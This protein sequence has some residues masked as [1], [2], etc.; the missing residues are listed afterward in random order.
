MA[1]APNPPADMT[2][3]IIILHLEDSPRDTELIRER[4][5]G[6]GFNAQVDWAASEPEFE[7]FLLRNDYDIILADYHVT[8]FEGP[9]SLGR[10]HALR[11]GTPYICVS[12]AIGEDCAVELLRLGAT[13]Y[14]SKDRLAR[15]PFVIRRALAETRDH[16]EHKSALEL[17]LREKESLLKEIHHRV[18]NNLQIVSSLLRLQSGRID[19]PAAKAALV[20]MQNRVRSM[21]L[22]H[23][24]LYGSKNLAQVDM[25]AY[26]RSLCPKLVRA[27]MTN[28]KVIELQL[29]LSP[30][31][32]EIDQAIPCG[33]LVNE[34]LTNALKHAFPD[35]RT[36][37]VRVELQPVDG[38]RQIRLLVADN[39][40]GLPAN[41]DVKRLSSLGL[42][43]VSD[44][45]GQL[46]GRLE[47]GP[48]PGA[49]FEVVFE[50]GQ[51]NCLPHRL[52]GSRDYPMP[53]TK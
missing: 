12:G 26:I 3:E 48:G 41:L 8:G 10:A 52:D 24:H 11:P 27:L 17:S 37:E 6:E 18:K 32:L 30:V 31:L 2:P 40:I 9:A 5:T 33:L 35:G 4:L 22:V 44:L 53:N 36:G 21:A 15:L 7:S 28:P 20:D 25:D 19:H 49:A 38:G 50:P 34:L 13:D 43:L 1:A 51:R 23:E 16:K 42:E 46:Q 47:I 45:T 39:G 14:V 29:N